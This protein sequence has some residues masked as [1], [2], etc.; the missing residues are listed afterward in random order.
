MK[1]SIALGFIGALC[2]TVSAWA[3]PNMAP[4]FKRG[5]NQTVTVNS[6]A[7][8]VPNWATSITA[9][10]PSEDA[11]QTVTFIITNNNNAALFSVSPAISTNGTLTFT[12]ANDYIGVA[13]LSVV[14][15]DNGGTALGGSDTSPTQTFFIAVVPAGN[16]PS[17]GNPQLVWSNRFNG[18]AGLIDQV[19][20][21]AT[22]G[23]GNVFVTGSSSNAVSALSGNDYVTLKY[24]ASGTLVWSANY[25][26]PGTGNDVARA[27]AVD[28]FG[29]V[30]VTGVSA[31]LTSGDD[32]ATIKYDGRTGAQLWVQRFDGPASGLDQATAIGLDTNGNVFVTGVSAALANKDFA[33][34]KYAGT[35]GSPIWT[36]RYNGPGNG[37]DQP[38]ALVVD[39]SGNPIVTGA[40]PGSASGDDYAT[41]KYNGANGGQVWASRYNGPGNSTDTGRALALDAGGNVYVTG[42]SRG[43]ASGD[44][45]ATIR[46]RGTDGFAVWTNRFNGT[47]NA[48]D[49]ARAIAVDS[50]TNV[51]VTGYS[52]NTGTG[53]DFTTIKYNG[54]TGAGIWTNKYSAGLNDQATALAVD[55]A[56]DVFVTGISSNAV[57]GMD[58][59]IVKYDSAGTAVW[60]NRLTGPGNTTDAPVAIAFDRLRNVY[61]S[62]YSDGGVSGLDYLT[63]RYVQNLGPAANA[64]SVS[65]VEDVPTAIT[66]T[67]SDPNGDPLSFTP[68]TPAHGTLSGTAPN[69]TYT[70]STNFNGS[71]SFT[72][73]V[74]DEY[75]NSAA[76][77]V[78]IT[79]TPVNDAPGFTKGLDQ[80]VL[81]DAGP[82][83]V[84][85]WATAIS[86]GPPNES[87]QSLNF[88]VSN[89]NHALFSV[90]PAISAAGTLTYTPAANA[91][92]FTTV[93]V[94][95]HDD[96]G[97]AD[98]GVDTSAAQTFTITI[99]PVNDAP[100]FT[101]GPDQTVN[102]DAGL[103]VVSGWA[104]AIGKGP[105]DE[106]GQTLTFVILNNSNPGLFSA[107]P[108]INT[109]TGNLSYTPAD[110]ANG[111]AT[112][113]VQLQDDGGTANGGTN[114]SAAQT[115]TITVNPVNDVPSFTKGANQ[116]ANEDAGPQS[117][118]NWA[119]AISTGPPSESGQTVDFIVSDDNSSLFSTQPAISSS[120]TLT[121]T[122]ATN[123]NGLANVTVRI[124][125]D[126]GTANGGVDTS[127][128]QTFTITVNA[129]NDAPVVTVATP[130]QTVLEDGT[131]LVAGLSVADVDLAETSVSNKMVM[132]L[133]VT[134]GI[135]TLNTTNGLTFT[136][137]TNGTPPFQ[138]ITTNGPNGTTNVEF[139]GT[140]QSINDAFTN[141]TYLANGNINGGDS[142]R[143]IANDQGNSGSG[144]SLM[145]TNFVTLTIT[146]VNDAPSFTKGGNQTVLED[147]GAQ[148]VSW[149]TGISAG[150]PDESGQMLEFIVTNDNNALF[151]VQPAI[152]T[153]GATGTLTYTLAANANGVAT[154]TVRLHDNGGTANG[155][156]D[157]SAPQTFT[158]TVTPVNDTPSFAFSTTTVSSLEDAGAQSVPN[159]ATNISAGPSDESAQTLNFI[160]S[161]DNNALFSVQP[162]ISANGTLTFTAKPDSNGVATVT[163]QLHDNG[164]VANGGSDTS[165]STNFNINV[166]AVNDAPVGV[167]DS[168]SSIAEDSG[169]RT[170]SIASLVANDSKGPPNESGENLTITAVSSAVGGTVSISGTDVVFTPATNYNGPASFVYT[171]RDNGQSGSP[172]TNDFK[173]STATVSFSITPVN[174]GPVV[175]V[176]TPSQ[177][178]LEDTSL[179]VAGVSVADVDLAETSPANELVLRLTVTNGILTL[180]TTNGLTFTT[181]TNITGMP[182]LQTTNITVNGANG[183]TNVEVRGT[184]SAINDAL[185]NL[186]YSPNANFN[187]S[188]GL[189]IVANDQGHSGAGGTLT[190]TNNVALIIIPM[191]DAPVGVND[192]L[193]DVAEDSG[194]RTNSFASLLPND[195]PGP[196][197][198]STQTLTIT[199]VGSAVGGTVSISGTNVIFT[200][201][202]NYNGPASYVYT[203][204]DNGQSGNPPTNDFKTA[205]AT[206]SFTITPVNDTP[207]ADPQS[208]TTAEDTAKAITLTGSDVETPSGNL[209]FAVTQA[210][211]HGALSGT[212]PNVTYTPVA[213]YNGPDSFKF[214]VTDTG[215]GPSPPKTSAE[216]TVTITVDP[217]NDAPVA[218]AQSVTTAEDTA[219]AITLTGSDLE[220]P[221]GSL[222][223]TVTQAPAHGAVSGTPPNVTHTPATNY[224]GP[225][226]FKFTV[227]DTGDGSAPPKTSAEATVT[228]TV[229]PVNDGPVVTVTT[230][231][232]SVLEDT[233]LLVAGVSVADVDL[234]ETSPANE[235]VL[236]LSVTNGNVTLNTTNGLTFT[237]TTNVTGMPPLQTTNLTVNG[238][239][240]TTN[241]EVRGTLSAINDALTNLTYSP[242]ANFNGSDGLQIVANDQGNSGAGG[243]LLD[244]NNIALTITTVNDA[245]SF[246]KGGDQTVNEDWGTT[247]VV[248]WATAISRGPSDESGQTLNFIVSNNNSN[249]FSIQPAVAPN[250]TLTYTPAADS[251]GVATVTVRLH[252]NGG[253]TNGGSDTSAAQTFT[254][255]VNAVN[256]APGFTLRSN[257]LTVLKNSGP[258]VIANLAT[259]FN[260]GP[261]DEQ[262]SQ[263]V[264]AFLVT[265]NNNGLFSAQPAIST[266]GTLTYTPAA[267]AIGTATVTNRLQD[268]GGTNSGGIDI[269]LPQTFTITVTPVNGQPNVGPDFL[270]ACRD[271]PMR[272][273]SS[274]L[275]SNDSDPDNDPLEIIGVSPTSAQG[276]T[277]SLSGD[278]RYVTYQPAFGYLGSDTFTYTVSDGAIEAAAVVTMNVVAPFIGEPMA[279]WTNRYNGPNNAIDTANAM[280]VDGAGNVYVT[281]A[282]DGGATTG[283]DYATIKYNYAGQL[284]WSNRFNG[285]ATGND[286]AK[287]ICLD[288]ATNV[289]VTGFSAGISSGSDYT[290]IKYNGVTG[291]PI[292]TNRFNGSGN[293]NDQA[294]AIAVDP[295]GNVVL[296]GSALRNVGGSND[297]VTVKLNATT[298]SIIWT[299]QYNGPGNGT[300]TAV[301]LAIDAAGNVIVTGASDGAGTGPDYVTLKIHGTG[302]TN[303]WVARY[304]NNGIANS[305]DVP[306]GLALDGEGNVYVTGSSMGSDRDYLTVKYDRLTGVQLWEARY[307]GLGSGDD[308]AR[309]IAV[310]K[311]GNVFVTGI[312]SGDFATIK[313]DTDGNPVWS[314]ASRYN[315][316]GNGTDQA[317][318]LVLDRACDVY[319]A[320]SS[321]GSGSGTDYTIVKYDGVS[322]LPVWASEARYNGPGN[323][324]DS[325]AALAVDLVGNV[326]VSGGSAGAGSSQDY[327]TLRLFQNIPPTISAFTNQTTAEDT[328]VGPI[329]F[330]VGDTFTPA[331]DLT[332]SGASS[333]TNLVPTNSYVFGGSDSNRTVTI[334][335]GTN[336][337]G[338]A[339][340]YISVSD[341]LATVS[342]S[343]QLTVTAVN[344]APVAVNDAY[345]NAEDTLLSVPA[346]GVMANDSDVETNALTATLVS[347]TTSGSLSFHPDGSFTYL[348]NTNFNG[349][350]SFTYKVNDGALDSGVATVVLTVT[351]V[352]DAPVLAPIGDRTVNEGSLL[353]FTNTA[354]D[355]END[356]LTF[357]LGTNAPAGAS[358]N[359]SNGVFTWTPTEAQGPGTNVITVTV[360][361]NG[362][363]NQSDSKNFTVI[364]N[365]VNSAP[366]LAAQTN[367]TINE[368]TTLTVTNTA[369]D[370]DIPA[371]TLT[372]SLS[373]TPPAGATINPTN[374]V[375]TWTP[376]EAQGPSTNVI[377]VTVTDNGSPNL[378]D[379]KSFTVFVNE[380]NSAPTLPT[381][382]DRTNNE[383][384]TLTVTNT[385]TDTDLPANNLT[386][387]FLAAPAG[388]ILDTNGVITWTPT[389]AQ[390][391]STNTFTTRVTDDGSPALSAT[392]T[393]TVIVREVNSAPVLPA[394]TNRTIAELTT[395]A[396]T[397]TATDS[398]IPA[399]TL[400]YVLQVGPTNA[401]I[402]A[403]GVITWTPTEAQGPGTNVFTTVVTDNGTPNLSATN[404]FMVVVTEVNSAPALP[405]QT[406]RT[407]AELTTLTVTNTASDSD[408]PTNTLSYA[409][410]VAP[411]NAAISSNGVITWTPTEA[412]GP[413][414]NTFTTVV[415]DNGAPPLS[416]TNTFTVTVTEVNSA[417]V[418]PAQTNR[419]IAELTTLIV[420]NTATDSDIPANTLSYTLTAGP[421]NAT[422]STNGVITWTPTEAQGPGTNVFTTVVTDNGTP[423]L[424]ATNS[425]TVVVTEV[426][427][428]PVLAVITNRTV[429]VGTSLS[430]T[431]TATDSDI[432][433][434]NL[435][436]SLGS[437]PAGASITPASGVFSWRPPVSRAGTTNLITVHVR[438]DGSP[439]L[440]DEK[441][442][443]VIV[444]PL[445]PVQLTAVSGTST[446]FVLSVSGDVGPD[447]TIQISTTLTNWNN[448]QTVTPAST[449]FTFTDT[450]T[451]GNTKRFY[452]ALLGP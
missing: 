197:N 282:S 7:H 240:G 423:N 54:A 404:T 59:A 374:G 217:V 40:S 80:T 412:Q 33:T 279:V 150:P 359:S 63:V 274:L 192:P 96:G 245:P 180:N 49:V 361:D 416:A 137:T 439:P 57:S 182:P 210:P 229:T 164:G 36:N 297:I 194:P 18:S 10:S 72:F 140:L 78:T 64:Q 431:A 291:V 354:T 139:S 149:G 126:G 160:V 397:N 386:Y 366:V 395:L 12:P 283:N 324:A 451:V 422:I 331:G 392:N 255:T 201:A 27:L 372:F 414:T 29:D 238:A 406:N 314:D 417:P 124:H 174:D 130:S 142:L 363:P 222:T 432:P 151:A 276:G 60:T 285:P 325:P 378:S 61:V 88:I 133:T 320:G 338:T 94:Q 134:N 219:K 207:T 420:T 211:A 163:V 204:R 409:L 86:N 322:G 425:F 309:A 200:P 90:Q 25:N 289:Y 141:L 437:P 69:L 205:T 39:A 17:V 268:N 342:N 186:T 440:S 287:A 364:V 262:A 360:T 179:L 199:A 317:N 429:N 224:N 305:P 402:S 321:V 394:Q 75:S 410:T 198:E 156:V 298:G 346:P 265:N 308:Q 119:T 452:R 100:T 311:A 112:I 178:V 419:T 413:S 169:P 114:G 212:A 433:T 147:A 369:T 55:Q 382:P 418:L 132:R 315:G 236:R 257:S 296:T 390:G 387:T 87:S 228:I 106:S 189:Q 24:D 249:L 335:P 91:N 185:T 176:T 195:S 85:G 400:S 358:I 92:G 328:P 435:F 58:F 46:Y 117:V 290:T 385:A 227:T 125:D 105:P 244:T 70:P 223:F 116:T 218:D 38:Y 261:P 292:W 313:Y 449:P 19:Y 278:Q 293:G 230:P 50:A 353:T 135:L 170:N 368:L 248:N 76:A 407:I 62:G 345:T 37:D 246:T 398:D 355:V 426:N 102:E 99:T 235:L 154:V 83:T 371:N 275:L 295:S 108:A 30:I 13:T 161:N 51:V 277:V 391:P 263:S 253:T 14:L 131:L 401:A 67:G 120:G 101:K 379:S 381:Q 362:S 288:A 323:G 68:T 42:S 121:F 188:D 233:P 442:F 349:T 307:L 95:L 77:T 403:D 280:A 344:D 225:D 166:I 389:E 405:V 341:G 157:S 56:N 357:S 264:L 254:I 111:T 21:M 396:V 15:R 421:T 5:P 52:Q 171:L 168:L 173:T 118:P 177:S 294:A 206:A 445:S 215:D 441:S 339:T 159:L 370:S 260:F 334:T 26:G 242:N 450:N 272:I 138:T 271:V 399:N 438:D 220:T 356:T 79:V 193:G 376:T 152:S 259:N 443:Q 411:A 301:A 31:G 343:F 6:G 436:F 53:D 326:F 251:N 11:A 136:T 329:T 45:Y 231:S 347:S 89:T 327:A 48:T 243:A 336:R 148:S 196:A 158:I 447:Y 380:V 428:A 316:P 284:V 239:N 232:Q 35:N 333:D 122:T 306:A 20:A 107:G 162:A 424:S 241:V 216:A 388:A 34:I 340:V 71:D 103:Q 22:D 273:P 384:A 97:T 393:F 258:Q 302:G 82:Q 44:D 299:N 350:D 214:T 28:A 165:A 84:A 375:F 269:S 73:T 129:V 2:L 43:S 155:G 32:Y 303:L 153:N 208:V 266:D 281:G 127:A 65:V 444:N 330:T 93:T 247:N 47:S 365:E 190:D 143:I 191:N 234:A 430:I 256:D 9:G 310:D 252:D 270:D 8:T 286:Q 115:F 337:F 113:T 319:V 383:L 352:N 250:G 123:A 184:L 377:T 221:S 203:L 202:A 167:N 226:S 237:T 98:G 128:A 446:Q 267:N 3:Q 448:L 110:N 41:V 312:S 318:V 373:G 348:P 304:S 146:A 351:P 183:T 367:R 23:G 144:G 109:G 187:G 145:N 74:N 175:T 213:N 104:T 81:E 181:T 16:P 209:T 408:M 4:S 427:S 66:L 332:V 1:N 172:L 434:N 415:T 300:D